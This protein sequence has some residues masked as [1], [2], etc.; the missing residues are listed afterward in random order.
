MAR[1]RRGRQSTSLKDKETETVLQETSKGQADSENAGEHAGENTGEKTPKKKRHLLRKIIGGILLLVVFVG[2]FAGIMMG[3]EY[4]RTETR[5]GE[6]VTVTVEKGAGSREVAD[7]LKRKGLIEYET[8]FLI[9][10]YRSAYR[11]QLRYGTYTL[12]TGM[13]VSDIIEKLSSGGKDDEY[14]LVVPEGF[15]VE[16]IAQRLE[17]KN[18]MTAE[19]FETAVRNAAA[20]F[21]Y[22]DQLPEASTVSYQLQGYLLPDTYYLEEGQS[23]EQL[24]QQMLDHFCENWDSE[25]QKKAEEAG[26][27]VT[28]VLTR[29]SLVIKETDLEEEYKI[30]AAVIQNRLDQNMRLQF[31]STV[32]YAISDGLYGVDRVLYSHLE[33]E[34]LYNTYLNNGLP[35]GPIDNPDF[36]AIDAVLNPDENDYLFFQYN[37][38]KND[39]SNLFFQTYEE[40]QQAA[41]TATRD[42][43]Q[44]EETDTAGATEEKTTQTQSE[45]TESTR[46]GDT[47]S[48]TTAN[49]S[50][51]GRQGI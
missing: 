45:E 9:K 11:G 49:S 28:E 23:A 43:E 37:T 31:D 14:T 25:R 34:S 24:V 38:E 21:L 39:G 15:S 44:T 50:E 5:D 4:F 18:M 20:D 3:H 46:I 27:T 29:A 47:S 12:N 19:E 8:V 16:Q 10:Y 6:N 35:P 2:L 51:K 42:Q 22:A 7:M 32:V 40:H 48:G 33:T 17:Q 1:K 41:A 13:T 26:M 30:I 36:D